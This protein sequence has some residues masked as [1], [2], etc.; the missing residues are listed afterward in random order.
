[1]ARIIAAMTLVFFAY[2]PAYAQNV[3]ALLKKGN[4]LFSNAEYQAAFDVFKQGYDKSK[5]KD[6][7][8]LRSMAFCQLKLYHHEQAR[9]YLQE[10][11]KKFP[12]APDFKKLKDLEASLEI[13]V[14]TKVSIKSN[15][16]G[17]SIYIDA[18]AAGKVGVTPNELTI[19]PGKHLVILKMD[20]YYT[21]T[22]S[23]EIK[24]KESK[25]LDV[26]LEVPI[27]ISSKPDG[28]SVHYDSPDQPTLGNTPLSIG[29]KPGQRKVYL[30]K[31][32]FKTYEASLNVAP[33]QKATVDAT[34]QIGIDVAS[35]PSGAAVEV[36]GKSV[37]GTTPLEAPVDGVGEHTVTVTLAPCNPHTEKVTVSLGQPV[38][39]N[40]RLG[41]CGLLNMRTD[42]DGAAVTVG[43]RK[44]GQ[45]PV[46]SAA[47]A[48]GSQK[49][50]INHPDRRPWSGALD[51]SDSE[52][53]DAKVTLGR[54]TWPAWTLAGVAGAS[55]L[56]GVIATGMA[57]KSNNDNE[58]E[59]FRDGGK[60]STS[61]VDSAGN[62]VDCPYAWHHTATAAYSVAG[63]S[64]VASF[65]YYWFWAR[66]KVEVNRQPV[67][68]ASAS[69]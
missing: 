10:Y 43:E 20:N 1:M 39:V 32:G 5:G 15:P 17:A 63:V 22:Q 30:K 52:M 24:P 40:A 19:E 59:K 13:V 69:R 26:I 44:V 31:E 62:Q 27:E 35:M 48:A 11:T 28:A 2:T 67:G 34:L 51:F 7:T 54:K 6:P 38:K 18:E 66:P 47:V 56:L 68:T 14:Q 53:V 16:P 45:T 25:A 49:I 8:S 41:G 60:T 42:V 23:M 9:K 12:K 21:T 37:D 46:A 4:Q 50:T 33:A 64:A 57:A 3:K 36:D 55:L 58:G 65:I 29:I 61:C